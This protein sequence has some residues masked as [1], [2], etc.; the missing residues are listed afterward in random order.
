MQEVKRVLFNSVPKGMPVMGETMRLTT[1]SMDLS[2]VPLH[3]GVLTKTLYL[4]LDPYMRGRMRAPELKSYR[5]PFALNE[6]IWSFALSK[7]VRSEDATLKPDDLVFGLLRA[8]CP[9]QSQM[10][11]FDPF[12][13]QSMGRILCPTPRHR[14][15]SD[16]HQERAEVTAV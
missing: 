7:V 14:Q 13:V 10:P 1:T 3:K 2:N 16:R 4:S 5:P 11:L 12:R 15:D 6:P 8:P 9:S